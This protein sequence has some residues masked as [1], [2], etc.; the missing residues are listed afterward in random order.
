MGTI[1]VLE[2]FKILNQKGKFYFAGSSEMFGLVKETPQTEN[3]AFNPRSPYGIS[4]TAGY[5]ATKNYREAYNMFACSGI[6]FNHESP[7]RGGEFVTQKII[8]GLNNIYNEKQNVL[9]LGNLDAKRDWGFSGDYVRA[10]HLML[11]Q[12]KADDYVIATG[13]THSI[14]EF[15]E[16]AALQFGYNIVWKGSGVNE[17]GLDKKTKKVIIKINPDFYR[18]AE[19][20]LLLGA[21][22]KAKEKLS[23]RPETDFDGL[24]KIMVDSVKKTV[25]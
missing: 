3:T 12:P 17:I 2:A 22:E 18:A 9:E 14:R 24:I 15:V 23:W 8:K 1:N 6:L 20:D 7:R 25:A 19:V 5:F 10:M 16:K 11:Q 4:K 21:A 13:E